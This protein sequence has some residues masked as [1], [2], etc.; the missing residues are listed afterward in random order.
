MRLGP[1]LVNTRS[2][3]LA[4]PAAAI[5]AAA[6]AFVVAVRLALEVCSDFDDIF[7]VVLRWVCI[8]LANGGLLS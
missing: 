2:V 4:L 8:D 6:W 7:D 1:H 5:S 3:S